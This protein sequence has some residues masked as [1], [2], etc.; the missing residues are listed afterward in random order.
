MNDKEARQKVS[1]M[2]MIAK[3]IAVLIC[4]SMNQTMHKELEKAND[5]ITVPPCM[6][7]SMVLDLILSFEICHFMAC[8][9]E[10]GIPIAKSYLRI[11]TI[12]SEQKAT[13]ESGEAAK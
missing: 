6:F 11:K 9:K 2:E 12:C 10:I 3:D 7:Q 13:I 5:K 4:E 8:N 1:E